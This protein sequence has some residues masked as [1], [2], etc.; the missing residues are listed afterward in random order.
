[1]IVVS[2][3]VAHHLTEDEW[4]DFQAKSL[5]GDPSSVECF[6]YEMGEVHFDIQF[7]DSSD[8]QCDPFGPLLMIVGGELIELRSDQWLRFLTD[9]LQGRVGSVRDYGQSWGQ[10]VRLDEGEIV[11]E[12]LAKA[13]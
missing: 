10:I 8:I 11:T 2:D 3:G 4:Q 1:M 12:V 7:P 5:S 9:Q 6:G 13:A